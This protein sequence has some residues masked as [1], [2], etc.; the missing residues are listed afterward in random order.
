MANSFRHS[1]RVGKDGDGFLMGLLHDAKLLVQT[2]GTSVEEQ[3]FDSF[4]FEK[5][6]LKFS[7]HF[8][9]PRT[10]EVY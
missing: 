6:R 8:G 5:F 4:Y 3:F 9:Q 10:L 7:T 2:I 1:S